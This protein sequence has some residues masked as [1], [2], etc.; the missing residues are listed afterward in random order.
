M[1]FL[2]WNEKYF[3]GTVRIFFSRGIKISFHYNKDLFG[4]GIILLEQQGSFLYWY[5]KIFLLGQQGYSL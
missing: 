3:I 2:Y 1:V 4:S 5:K